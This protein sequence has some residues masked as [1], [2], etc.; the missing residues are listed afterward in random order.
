MCEITKRSPG[1]FKL[2]LHSILVL[3]ID[4]EHPHLVH[5]QLAGVANIDGRLCQ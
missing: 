5:Q 4:D 3:S 2:L 1:I